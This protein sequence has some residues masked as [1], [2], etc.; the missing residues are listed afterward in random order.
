VCQAERCGAQIVL[1]DKDRGLE[2]LVRALEGSYL[3]LT[4]APGLGSGLAPLKRL[5]NSPEDLTFLA[6]MVRACIATPAPYDPTPEE[7]RRISIA[8]RHVMSGPPG[9]RSMAEVRAFLGA[10]RTGAGA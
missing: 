2:V 9:D 8:L 7:D 5:T 1:W 4:N 6:A 3:S 10:D